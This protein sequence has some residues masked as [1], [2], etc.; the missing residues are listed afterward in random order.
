MSFRK[1]DSNDFLLIMY[2]RENISDLERL[3]DEM[4]LEAEQTESGRDT[5]L[6]LSH[7]QI[8][9]STE[10]SIIIRFL[11]TLPGTGRFLRLVA[12]KYVREILTST[13]IHR[14]P[15]LIIYDNLESLQ[16]STAPQFMG[17][18]ESLVNN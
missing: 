5:V 16:L 1:F 8:I 17:K 11:K 10:I 18:L 15:N 6:D 3:R 4:A 9:S 13:N 2:T 7:L 12:S 14:I